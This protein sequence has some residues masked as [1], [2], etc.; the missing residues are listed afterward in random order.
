MLTARWSI[1]FLALLVGGRA[2]QQQDACTP[3]EAESDGGALLQVHQMAVGSEE[4]V[5]NSTRPSDIAAL[6]AL[7]IANGRQGTLLDWG[8]GDPCVGTTAQPNNQGFGPWKG[9]ACVPCPAEARYFCVSQIWQHQKSLNG[10]IPEKFRGLTELRWLFLSANNLTGPMPEDNWVTFP[11]LRYLDISY[12]TINGVLPLQ[13][14][15]LIPSLQTVFAHD[16]HFD[17]VAYHGGGFRSLQTMDFMYN[18]N[19]SGVF[20]PAFAEVPRLRS[21]QIHDTNLTG[22]LPEGWPKIENLVITG[23]G[24]LCGPLPSA[25]S[26]KGVFCDV[27]NN[28]PNC[29]PAPGPPV[30]KHCRNR[31]GT[32]FVC[33]AESSCCGDI[34][35]GKG[36]KCCTNAVDNNFA[37]GAGSS[38]CGNACAAAGSKCCRPEGRPKPEWYPVTQ[39]TAC[40]A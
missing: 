26:R 25:C 38:C 28:F 13:R 22:P 18:R 20:P 29:P 8:V 31:Y 7:W 33:G 34:C 16:N 24:G 35:V 1:A 36:G 12:N 30:T 6:C 32:P 23:T 2:Q 19:M 15:S 4:V 37:C 21:L 5:R 14:L 17:S 39:A 10:T 27:I 3:F 9:V 40:R 11:K